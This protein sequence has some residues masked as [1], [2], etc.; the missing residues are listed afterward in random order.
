MQ[1]KI[2]NALMLIGTLSMSAGAHADVFQTYNVTAAFYEPMLAYND[3][4]SCPEGSFCTVFNGSF[5]QNLTTGTVTDLHGTMN[6]SMSLPVNQPNLT[7]SYQLS[8]VSDGHGGQLVSAFLLN[9]TDVFTGGG[10]ATGAGDIYYGWPSK[11]NSAIANAFIT[12]DV[13]PN[14][15]LTQVI[16]GDCTELGMMGATCMTG[17]GDGSGYFNSGSM[18]A[19]PVFQ[20]I[21]PVPEPET[22]AMLTAGLSVLGFVARRR[23]KA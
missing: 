20:T 10:F 8:S 22:Y 16:Y 14:P 3:G 9:T 13:N 1:R 2:R 18:G 5:T 23:R 4:P 7:L 11:W 15:T 19:Y 12:I 21:T 6:S 17:W